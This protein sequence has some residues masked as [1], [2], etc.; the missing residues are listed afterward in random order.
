MSA[1]RPVAARLRPRAGDRSPARWRRRRVRAAPAGCSAPRM[2]LIGAL[3]VFGIAERRRFSDR[4]GNH[5]LRR[6]GDD[7]ERETV[8]RCRP[9]GFVHARTCWKS[10]RSRCWS[11]CCCLP[12]TAILSHFADFSAAAGKL[13]DAEP[14]RHR[15][16]A[17]HR[18][19]RQARTVAV[20]RMVPDRLRRG[21]RRVRRADVRRRA[22]CRLLRLEPRPAGLGARPARSRRRRRSASSSSS[23][24]CSAP[25]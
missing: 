2:S 17:C 20:L 12:P 24:Q 5:E 15:R 14:R 11:R 21:Q 7:P 19:R 25:S 16:A 9:A 6:R 3:G 1:R 23:S 4:L 22:Q 13:A 10:A 8:G 18:L